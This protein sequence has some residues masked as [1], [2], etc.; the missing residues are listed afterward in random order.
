[1]SKK[2]VN[3]QFLCKVHLD[4]RGA[5]SRHTWSAQERSN[6][7]VAEYYSP[8]CAEGVWSTQ[9]DPHIDPS[10]E[11]H[12][13]RKGDCFAFVEILNGMTFVAARELRERR[14]G[15]AVSRRERI[16]L[17]VAILGWVTTAVLTTLKLLES[18]G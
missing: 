17:V 8:S 16:T 6:G 18:L 7:C 5:E 14:Q 1:M 2:C 11:I 15:T 13:N 12:K 10:V 9:V 4:N 3:C